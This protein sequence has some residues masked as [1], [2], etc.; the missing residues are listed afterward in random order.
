MALFRSFWITVYCSFFSPFFQSNQ[1]YVL[2]EPEWLVIFHRIQEG[3]SRPTRP[4]IPQDISRLS[5]FTAARRK[6]FYFSNLTASRML[7]ATFINC[8]DGYARASFLSVRKMKMFARSSYLRHAIYDID[9]R[10]EALN[11]FTTINRTYV[12]TSGLARDYSRRGPKIGRLPISAQPGELIP[13]RGVFHQ[14]FCVFR[15]L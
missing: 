4:R 8:T 7:I 11:A 9:A 10:I 3:H 6:R 5:R 15:P 14:D 2:R 12:R 1:K 13:C